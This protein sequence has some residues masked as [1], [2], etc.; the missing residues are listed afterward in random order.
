MSADD[1]PDDEDGRPYEVF[2]F[3]GQD[4]HVA[5][6]TKGQLYIVMGMLDVQ[7]EERIELQVEAVNNFGVVIK[8]LFTR[9]ADRQFVHRALAT[10]SIDLPEFFEL[11]V[12]M[13]NVWAAEEMDNREQRRKTASKMAPAKRAARPARGSR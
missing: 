2:T 9:G 13:L 12:D 4:I 6:P 11:A 10:G 8:H 7:D 3:G 1:A 5:Q